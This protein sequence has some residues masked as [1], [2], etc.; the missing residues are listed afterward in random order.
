MHQRLQQGKE[1]NKGRPAQ[2]SAAIAVQGSPQRERSLSSKLAWWHLSW[3]ARAGLLQPLHSRNVVACCALPKLLQPSYMQGHREGSSRNLQD[4]Q[5][6]MSMQ[7]C[8][9][10]HMWQLLMLRRRPGAADDRMAGSLLEPE[11]QSGTGV[12]CQADGRMY[13]RGAPLLQALSTASMFHRHAS[14]RHC[15]KA[16]WAAQGSQQVLR[17][18][19]A[20]CKGLQ[21]GWSANEGCWGRVMVR[22]PGLMQL[23]VT[24]SAEVGK[25]WVAGQPASS[26][27]VVML[28]LPLLG[29]MT[30]PY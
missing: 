22:L 26:C 10:A 29:I 7:C 3:A 21:R 25:L 23:P 14:G 2:L 28:L 6:P 24:G 18:R 17:V 11:L 1:G 5:S 15:S 13:C 30:L 27:A 16:E 4:I 20:D 8:C 12:G 9:H 19:T